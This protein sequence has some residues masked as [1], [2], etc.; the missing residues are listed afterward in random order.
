MADEANHA[1]AELARF[2]VEFPYPYKAVRN[3]QVHRE[4][5]EHARCTLTLVMTEKDAEICLEKGSFDDSIRVLHTG[6]HQEFWFAGG[7][8]K[9][10]INVEDGIWHVSVEAISRS[11]V[12]DQQVRQ[13]S[14]QN[15]N[16][17]YTSLIEQLAERYP[18]GAAMNEATHPESKIGEL[19]VQYQETD[20]QFLKRIAS[21]VGTA[22]LPDIV[23]D[24][25]RVYFGV[26]DFSWN[27]VLQAKSY[28]MIKDQEAYLHQLVGQGDSTVQGIHTVGY[29]VNSHQYVQVGDNVSFKGQ[30][31]VVYASQLT[32]KEGIMNYE[33]KLVQREGIRVQVRQNRSIQG[34][35]LEGKVVKR[36][37]NMVQVHLDIDDHYDEQTNWWFPYS[38][39]GN[40]MF[41]ALPEEG[42]RIKV[43]FPGGKEKKA[44]AIN[45]VRGTHEEMKGRTVFQKP[46]TKVFHVPGNAK[47]E[48]GEEGVL[49]EHN[50]VRL[51]LDRENIHLESEGSLLLVAGETLEFGQYQ[52]VPDYIKMKAEEEIRFFIGLED[53]IAVTKN[54]VGLK[55]PK[56]DIH[57]VEMSFLDML[58]DS[59]MEE[60]YLDAIMD[61]EV[62]K[63]KKERDKDDLTKVFKMGTNHNI[64]DKILGIEE[65][66]EEISDE[67]R[68]QVRERARQRLQDEPDSKE[69]V[70]AVVEDDGEYVAKLRYARHTQPAE[71]A[72]KSRAEKKRE[73][74]EYDEYYAK[75][76][77]QQKDFR[78]PVKLKQMQQEYMEKEAKKEAHKERMSEL[79]S[80]ITDHIN[81]AIAQDKG[82]SAF[83][84]HI[85]D[86][87]VSKLTQAKEWYTL[88]Y[89]IPQKPDYLSKNQNSPVYYSRY[90]IEKFVVSPQKEAAAW[91]FVFGAIALITAIPTGGSSMYLYAIVSGA[92]GIS[93]MVVSSMKLEDLENENYFKDPKFLGMNQHML[94][95]TGIA[96]SVVDL[97]F[98]IRGAGRVARNFIN[99][100]TR[101]KML[102]G[103]NDPAVRRILDN[104]GRRM[105]EIKDSLPKTWDEFRNSLNLGFSGKLALETGGKTLGKNGGEPWYLFSEGKG[106]KNSTG[107]G[108]STKPKPDPETK[109][110]PGAEGTGNSG[111]KKDIY[112]VSREEIQ[113]ALEG[114]EQTSKFTAQFKGFEVKAQ[115]SLSNM[116]DKEL[117]YSFKK[118]YSPKDGANDTII[119]HHHEQRVEGPIIEM[120]SRY[121]DLGNKRQHPFGN[122]GGVGSG[123]ARQEFNNW[124]KE[125]WKARYANEM[126]KRGIIK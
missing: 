50:T 38:S 9:V 13:R 124:R 104:T 46:T 113:Q 120:P 83:K 10:E 43:Y 29:L 2:Q 15:K 125:Y 52:P 81:K 123:G 22:I 57:K 17:T 119:L 111:S 121:H 105:G 19:L 82:L 23:L 33:Y 108:N 65:K 8:S 114:Y 74:A 28:T 96:L 21:K 1:V 45:S 90:Y 91:N 87:M 47:M 126:I 11:Y 92:W 39:E 118:G 98:L 71:E 18:G 85:L 70:K 30:L 106:T 42:A 76:V 31:W 27:K 55:T 3:I 25:P 88:D 67:E 97:A 79:G 24:A 110:Q 36:A 101:T 48:L 5:N 99:E 59:E 58:T 26:P 112:K 51:H 117:I 116:S 94:D 62:E 7:I 86:P 41:H 56:V 80:T 49:F 109:P 34:V 54:K 14:Y 84:E 115:R 53:F 72:E 100:S 35:A 40:N 95:V 6:E 60:L 102:T 93:Q 103:I 20:W 77:Q 107:K 61:D 75:Y 78:D 73:R 89:V 122:K 44:I 63:Y 37:N 4:F 16:L 64:I 66:E 32:Y 69:K 68:E 12:M